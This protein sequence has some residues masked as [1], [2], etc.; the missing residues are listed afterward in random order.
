MKW[1]NSSGSRGKRLTVYSLLGQSTEEKPLPGLRTRP[2]C[3]RRRRPCLPPRSRN[4]R[5]L[6]SGAAESVS[7]RPPTRMRWTHAPPLHRLSPRRRHRRRRQHY[8]QV[9]SDGTMLG[10][11]RRGPSPAW[12]RSRRR[13][14]V[15]CRDGKPSLMSSD[16]YGTPAHT[17]S[18]ARLSAPGR[19]RPGRREV[20]TAR[21]PAGTTRLPAVSRP[22]HDV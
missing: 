20:H 5:N 15:R 1:D 8:W 11:W 10:S 3:C 18:T 21:P 9:S 2:N 16:S 13:P 19:Q 4:L 12:A 7:P 22:V 6:L 14:L 17:V